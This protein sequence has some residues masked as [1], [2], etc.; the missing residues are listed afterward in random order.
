M[1]RSLIIGVDGQVG[2]ALRERLGPEGLVAAFWDVPVDGGV[3]FDLREAARKPAVAEKLIDRARPDVVYLVGALTWVDGCEDDPDLAMVV[4]CEGPAAVARVARA[5]GARCVFYSSDYVFD[6]E[7]GPYGERDRPNPICTY[8]R[9]KLQAELAIASEDPDALIVRTTGVYGPEEQGK[10]FAYQVA[11]SLRAGRAMRV[12]ADQ[13][14]NPT[15]NRDLA[16][17]TARLVEAGAKGVY[18]VAG[19]ELLDRAAFARRLARLAG[20]DPGPIQ[21]VTTD[22]L[23]QKAPRPLRAGLRTDKL[24]AALPELR[25]RSVER[26]VEDWMEHPRGKEWPG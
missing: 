9:S 5:C 12:P 3:R 2:G 6:G 18:H 15:Y 1:Q 22:R 25:L 26:A 13:V 7:S 4:N 21:P 10:N 20:L 17:A 11:A 8:G 14:A 16:E 24:L 19:P 23:G